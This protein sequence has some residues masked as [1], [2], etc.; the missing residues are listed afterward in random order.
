VP[1]LRIGMGEEGWGPVTRH[2]ATPTTAP[3][4]LGRRHWIVIWTEVSPSANDPNSITVENFGQCFFCTEERL[5]E[6]I[7]GEVVIEEGAPA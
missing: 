1:G 5:R 3:D 7:R 6:L 2:R 4:G